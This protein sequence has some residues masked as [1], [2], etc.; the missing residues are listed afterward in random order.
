M[1]TGKLLKN[2]ADMNLISVRNTS[3]EVFLK[4]VNKFRAKAKK[5]HPS[6][7]EIAKE[8]ELVRSARY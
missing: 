3:D 6:L 7:K 1:T 4:L 2:M 8:V 5:K